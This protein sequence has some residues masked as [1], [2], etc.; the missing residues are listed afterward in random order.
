MEMEGKTV[1]IIHDVSSDKR[2]HRCKCIN[3]VIND[4]AYV[5]IEIDSVNS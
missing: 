5:G 3:A 2:L 1:K 4:R